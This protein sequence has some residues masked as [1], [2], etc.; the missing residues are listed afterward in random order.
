MSTMKENLEEKQS[1]KIM[2]GVKGAA[3]LDEMSAK[4]SLTR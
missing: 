2:V 4:P 1:K 3:I